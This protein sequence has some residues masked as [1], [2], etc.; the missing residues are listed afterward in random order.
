MSFNFEDYIYLLIR[1][2]DENNSKFE[3]RTKFNFIWKLRN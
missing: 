2:K 1:F 3:T